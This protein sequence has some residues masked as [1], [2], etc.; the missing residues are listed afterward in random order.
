M[1]NCG[2][3]IWPSYFF[4]KL[5]DIYDIISGTVILINFNKT[6]LN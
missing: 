6:H 5:N 2:M 4:V 3:E 1:S